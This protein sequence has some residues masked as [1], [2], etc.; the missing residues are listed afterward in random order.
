MLPEFPI[1]KRTIRKS[2]MD[3][4]EFACKQHSGGFFKNIPKHTL[5]EG[6]SMRQVYSK[7]MEL[8]TDMKKLEGKF[9]V[10]RDELKADP[11]IIYSKLYEVATTFAAQQ[12]QY[13]FKTIN[14]V[15]E[16]TGNVVNS[17]GEYK[18]EDFFESLEKV[19]IDFD[20]NGNPLFPT[21][22]G[23]PAVINRIMDVLKKSEYILGHKERIEQIVALKKQQWHDRENNRKLAD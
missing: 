23:G 18:V 22:V 2:Q 5:E 16:L 14:D 4:F 10:S 3:F 11:F 1:A 6:N 15:T 9:E 20:E 12:V 17:Q 13:M 7:E 21:I 19:Q 8:D